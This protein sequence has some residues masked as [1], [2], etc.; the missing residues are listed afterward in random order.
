[1]QDPGCDL[2]CG[3][4]KIHK[5]HLNC[6]IILLSIEHVINKEAPATFLEHADHSK[7]Y[8]QGEVLQK[9]NEDT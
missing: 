9:K 3:V 4:I 8:F 1:M 7:P 6:E 2:S 5:G